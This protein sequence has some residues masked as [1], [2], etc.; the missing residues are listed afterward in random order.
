M[1]DVVWEQY[2]SNSLMSTARG[3]RRNLLNANVFACCP[4]YLS[5]LYKYRNSKITV[6]TDVVVL[7]IALQQRIQ[8]V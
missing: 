2:F 7:A 6:D 8:T 4:C 5:Q 3:K 1:Y